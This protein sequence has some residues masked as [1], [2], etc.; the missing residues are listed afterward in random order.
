MMGLHNRHTMPLMTNTIQMSFAKGEEMEVERAD[1][2]LFIGMLART[3]TEEEVRALV[4]PY[5]QVEEVY[6]MKDK[7]T[8][9]SKGCSFV[10][11]CNK[12][13][14]SAVIDALHQKVTMPGSHQP[15]IA[16]W[17]DAPKAKNGGYSLGGMGG[18]M[19]GGM[20]MGGGGGDMGGYG[21]QQQQGGYGMQQQQQQQLMAQQAA[22][23]QQ[24]QLVLQQQQQQWGMQSMPQAQPQMDMYGQY[25]STAG[26]PGDPALQMMGGQ[27]QAAL[28]NPYAQMGQ[29]PQQAGMNGMGGMAG[30]G[31]GM[32][33]ET[34]DWGA[35]AG[36]G[37]GGMGGGGMGGNGMGGGGMGGG[38]MGGGGMGGG[39]MGGSGMGG[40]GMGMGMGMGGG[41][42]QGQGGQGNKSGPAGC[43]LFIYQIPISW[44][45]AEINQCFSP[46]GTMVS[47][48]VFK[49]KMT[50]QS[51][52]FGFVS[53]DNAMSAQ[54]AIAAMNGMQIDGRRLKVELKKAKGP[55]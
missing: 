27:Q 53:Y 44:G 36:A 14:A 35:M 52:G 25:G 4:S 15:I 7:A 5:G 34:L 29:Q 8:G 47:G 2:K 17:A 9:Q 20:G 43:N 19:D 55:Y 11:F 6:I 21:M 24:Q 16:K 28:A 1:A 41:G 26:L 37:M 10:K 40:G 33:Q 12:E 42:Q 30:M 13:S 39:G 54:S 46:F 18:G 23:I 48:T 49:D 3:A 32:G 51:K 31:M 45:D 22:M 50:Q 38:G